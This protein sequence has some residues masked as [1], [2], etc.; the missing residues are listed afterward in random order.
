MKNLAELARESDFSSKTPNTIKEP[1]KLLGISSIVYAFS[2]PEF[3]H[4]G[5]LLNSSSLSEMYSLAVGSG[6]YSGYSDYKRK[7]LV[8]LSGLIASFLPEAYMALSGE[9]IKKVALSGAIK[10]FGY[11][12]G[13]LFGR[14]LADRTR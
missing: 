2:F 7:N 12:F 6:L 11:G 10:L 1:L 4:I 3:N 13:N 14:V 9:D 8:S 5:K